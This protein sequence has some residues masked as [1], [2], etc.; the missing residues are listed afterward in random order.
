MAHLK[1][2]AAALPVRMKSFTNG[3]SGGVADSL[4]EA[5]TAFR[6]VCDRAGIG[7]FSTGRLECAITAP[8]PG[9][10]VRLHVC[11][12]TRRGPPEER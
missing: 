2:R 6:A 3:L 8:D 11:H 10:A 5:K 4:D 1:R 9:N 12:I 7:E